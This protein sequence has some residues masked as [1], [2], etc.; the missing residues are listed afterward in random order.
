MVSRLQRNWKVKRQRAVAAGPGESAGFS[1]DV[2]FPLPDDVIFVPSARAA[3]LSS[4]SLEQDSTGLLRAQL[5]AGR[6]L[7][8]LNLS[9]RTIQPG[10][11]VWE[12]QNEKDVAN[13]P[14]AED[15]K[16]DVL[17]SDQKD[18]RSAGRGVGEGVDAGAKAAQAVLR[19][20]QGVIYDEHVLSLEPIDWIV[21]CSI[22]VL[23]LAELVIPKSGHDPNSTPSVPF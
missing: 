10:R 16:I 20:I 3:A 23:F 5:S 18:P 13:S 2:S 12:R 6:P 8:K 9:L 14:A 21:R 22:P 4:V 19:H 11:T 15:S 7:N 17:G 1:I